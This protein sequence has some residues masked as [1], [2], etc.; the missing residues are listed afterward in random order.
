MKKVLIAFLLFILAGFFGGFIRWFF[1][2]SKK[3]YW[4]V[5]T[6]NLYQNSVLGILIIAIFWVIYENWIK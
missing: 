6:S 4:D 1:F 5:L 2:N 3:R